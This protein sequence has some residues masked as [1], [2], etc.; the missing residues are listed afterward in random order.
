MK[1]YYDPEKKRVVSTNELLW[2][3]DLIYADDNFD[4]WLLECVNTGDYQPVDVSIEDLLNMNQAVAATRMYR[5]THSSTLREAYTA[6][7][8]MKEKVNRPDHHYWDPR[9]HSW[10]REEEIA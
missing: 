1:M 8:A 7:S 9:N 5:D 4:R 3:Y 10:V 2:A 6:I